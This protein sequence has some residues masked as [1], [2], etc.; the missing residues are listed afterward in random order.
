[1]TKSREELLTEMFS[2]I[3]KNPGIRPSE[4]NRLL[5]KPHTASLRKTLIKRGLIRKEKKGQT[6]HYFPIY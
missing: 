2:L 6:V 4:L 3:K 5:N 1:M